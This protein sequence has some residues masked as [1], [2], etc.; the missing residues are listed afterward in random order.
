MRSVDRFRQV[1][2]RQ[3]GEGLLPWYQRLQPREQ[4]LLGLAAFALPMILLVFGLLLPMHDAAQQLQG[5]VETLAG[6]AS[7]AGRLA[8]ALQRQGSGKQPASNPM[9]TI[10]QAAQQ[11]GV[12]GFIVRIRPEAGFGNRQQ[13]QVHMKDAPYAEVVKFLGRLQGMGMSVSRAKLYALEQP[14]M[15]D[16]ELSLAP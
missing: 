3:L 10:E 1:I 4:K 15:V 12:R 14:G 13:M 2:G 11:T 6:Q 9:T 7:E 8:D 5:D 16:V